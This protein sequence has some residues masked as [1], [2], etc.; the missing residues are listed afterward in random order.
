MSESIN[1]LDAAM[2]EFEA[3]PEQWRFAVKTFVTVLA[4]KGIV[5]SP[6]LLGKF[7]RITENLLLHAEGVS[8]K[9]AAKKN[10]KGPGA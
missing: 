3:L 9:E 5:Y 4:Q 1:P 10:G 2:A 8:K 7:R 6:E